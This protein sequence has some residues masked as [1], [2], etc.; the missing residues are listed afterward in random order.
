[1]R[2]RRRDPE[3]F[4][5]LQVTK[6]NGDSPTLEDMEGYVTIF[7]VLPLLPGLATFYY[8]LFEHVQA[9]FPYTVETLVL[10]YNVDGNDSATI[11][12]QHSNPKTILLQA[13]SENT[14]VLDYLL[15][16]DVVAGNPDADLLLDRVTIFLVS[17]DGMFIEQLVTP[18]M[19]L[20]ERRVSVF[21]KQLEAGKEL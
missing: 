3:E 15:Q 16:S 14:E 11:Q 5:E 12:L 9:I 19:P 10:R 2:E 21:L 7:A 4:F 13:T 17:S 1:M 18:T 20:L 8:E 6:A